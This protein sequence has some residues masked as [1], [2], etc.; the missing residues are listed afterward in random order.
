MTSCITNIIF[1]DTLPRIED[2]N[3]YRIGEELK[4][5]W[6]QSAVGD[7]VGEYILKYYPEYNIYYDPNYDKYVKTKYTKESQNASVLSP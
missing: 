1:E 3:K 2:V 6:Y 7:C 5:E 4:I